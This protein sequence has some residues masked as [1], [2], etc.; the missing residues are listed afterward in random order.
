MAFYLRATK[1]DETKPSILKPDD[2]FGNAK[3]KVGLKSSEESVYHK[4]LKGR[5][6][7]RRRKTKKNQCPRHLDRFYSHFSLLC[8][9]WAFY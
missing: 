2:S 7:R 4:T 1:Q 9:G 3:H 8:R 5:G 6:G